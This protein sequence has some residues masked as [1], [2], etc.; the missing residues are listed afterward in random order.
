MLPAK[1]AFVDVETTGLRPTYDRII[2]IG[3][4]RVENGVITQTFKSLIDPGFTLPS[5]ITLLTGVTNQDLEGAPSFREVK[6]E[7]T[8]ILD[9]CVMM[10]HN[11][12]FDYSF[13]KNEYKRQELNF[14]PKHMCTVK[15][16][17]ALFPTLRR[18]DLSTIIERFNIE[19]QNRHRAFDDAL[20]L[21]NFYQIIQSQ[22]T[23]DQLE[24]AFDKVAK[25]PTLPSSLPL[26]SFE[27]LPEG[28]GVYIF[29]GDNKLPLYIGKSVNIR[30]R[31]MS[32][33]SSDHTS[34]KEMKIAQQ[35]KQIETISTSGELGALFKESLLIKKMQPLYNRALRYTQSLVVIKK[36]SLAGYEGVRIESLNAID[37]TELDQ[38]LGVFRSNQAAK[39]FLI[40]IAKEYSLCEKLL[41]IEKTK[42][43]CFAYRL[44]RCLGACTGK[45]LNLKYNLRFFEAF[46]ET[47]IKPW[48]FSGPIVIKEKDLL[49]EKEDGFLI[50]KWCYI[51][52]LSQDGV[53]VINQDYNFDLDAYKILHRFLREKKNWSSIR[54]IS[55]M[56]MNS[57]LASF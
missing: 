46:S 6:E 7:I 25:R 38:I 9:G 31:V 22:F 41:G 14:S 5:E 57:L 37:T 23:K 55:E 8:Q 39:T 54:Q 20:V 48:P 16:S 35:I 13:L 53:E 26:K 17:R 27:T 12:R 29:Y 30:A 40:K 24:K 36:E 15:L 32:H 44:G 11:A 43:A 49:E 18:H 2:E 1:I 51:G 42:E 52:K 4:I 33:F 47:K 19:C 50:H 34:S 45:E 28:P 21:W 56:E 3:I 10:A